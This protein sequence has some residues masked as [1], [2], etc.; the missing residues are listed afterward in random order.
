M[1]F[2]EEP[3]GAGRKFPCVELG[4]LAPSALGD[5]YRKSDV[6]VVFSTTNYSLVP[7]EMMAC[8][9]PVVEIDTESTRTAFPSGSLELAS[10]TPTSVADAIERILDVPKLRAERIENARR[11]V[12]GL[13][14]ENSAKA[15]EAALLERFSE[16]E[17]QSIDPVVATA[18]LVKKHRSVSVIIP[19]YNGSDRFRQVLESGCVA[20][21]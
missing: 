10:S 5:T 2:G 13:S 18:P 12:S 4:I 17:F 9:L 15:V 16:L 20:K 21:M 6:G 7:L 3:D 11:F 14:W 19:T 1:L 8:D